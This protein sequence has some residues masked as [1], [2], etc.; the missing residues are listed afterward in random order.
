IHTCRVFLMGAYKY[1]REMSWITG[2]LLLF[3]TLGMGFTG[4]LLRWDQDA[5]WAVVLAAE[6]AGRTPL[7]GDWLAQVIIACQTVGGATLPRCHAWPV[8]LLPALTFGLIGVHLYLVVRHGSSEPPRRGVPV[9][10]ATYRARYEEEIH[11]RGV[12]FWPDAAWKDVV[13]AL[14]V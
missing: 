6:M 7:I 5:Y 2:T 13:F 11:Q 8:C 1:P 12:P 3:C 14:A 4:Q 9:D 10:P